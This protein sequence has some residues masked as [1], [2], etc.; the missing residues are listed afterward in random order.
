V[1]KLIR[2]LLKSINLWITLGLLIANGLAWATLL[3][4]GNIR[5]EY[6]LDRAGHLYHPP[7]LGRRN[8]LSMIN[9]P[10]PNLTSTPNHI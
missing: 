6:R 3:F 9:Q 7:E 5:Q 1:R 10:V 8:C 2:T 4:I